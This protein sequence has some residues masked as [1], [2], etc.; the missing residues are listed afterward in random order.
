MIATAEKAW[1]EVFELISATAELEESIESIAAGIREEFNLRDNDRDE[2]HNMPAQQIE[3]ALEILEKIPWSAWWTFDHTAGRER[4][5]EHH[6][7]NIDYAVECAR[8]CR[9][10]VQCVRN[11]IDKHR[12]GDWIPEEIAVTV[13]ETWAEVVQKTMEEKEKKRELRDR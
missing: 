8:K 7:E 2:E 6:H 4:E 1:N 10:I 13:V 12:K 3:K 5:W 11:S 9:D